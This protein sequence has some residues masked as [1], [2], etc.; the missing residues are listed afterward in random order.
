MWEARQCSRQ[1]LRKLLR[2]P[3]EPADSIGLH[4]WPYADEICSAD[5]SLQRSASIDTTSRTII[6]RRIPSCS[7]LTATE[8]LSA[9]RFHRVHAFVHKVR[10]GWVSAGA[11]THRALLPSHI[12]SGA[13]KAS[14]EMGLHLRWWPRMRSD[15][16]VSGHDTSTFLSSS[17]RT[18]HLKCRHGNR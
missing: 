4:P 14:A 11:A 3:V 15:T 17:R 5:R 16:V 12:L 8:V 7:A 2:S 18:Y 9:P 1:T 13:G 6:S 10:G